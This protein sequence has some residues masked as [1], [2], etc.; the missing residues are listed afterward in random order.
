MVAK[1]AGKKKPAAKKKPAKKKPAKKTAGG[2]KPKALFPA[3]VPEG[4]FPESKLGKPDVEKGRKASKIVPVPMLSGLPRSKGGPA[5][6][7]FFKRHKGRD[8]DSSTN[9]MVLPGF[10]PSFLPGERLTGPSK[11][12]LVYRI[13]DSP[14]NE[15]ALDAHALHDGEYVASWRCVIAPREPLEKDEMA[16]RMFTASAIDGARRALGVIAKHHGAKLP[17]DAEKFKPSPRQYH[18]E[19]ATRHAA[20]LRGAPLYAD[21]DWSRKAD[22]DPN[23]DFFGAL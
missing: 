16:L 21:V 3:K 20:N 17:D 7:A 11:W 9:M 15:V 8:L 13:V 1:V 6:K 12:E 18:K 5:W 10:D 23:D 2:G 4:F 14:R 22:V 19:I